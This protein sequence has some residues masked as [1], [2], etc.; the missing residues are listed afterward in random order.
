[1]D[2]EGWGCCRAVGNLLAFLSVSFFK[3]KRSYPLDKIDRISGKLWRS[4]AF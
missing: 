4:E 2:Q 3:K 1:M